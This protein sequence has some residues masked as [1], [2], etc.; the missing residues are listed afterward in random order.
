MSEKN[1]KI[2]DT[3]QLDLATRAAWL[4]YIGG[5]TQ[6]EV[7]KRLQVSPVKAHRLI[8]QAQQQGI[9]KI[10][11]EGAVASCASME[12]GDLRPGQHRRLRID[13]IRRLRRQV[14]LDK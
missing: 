4:S 11:I 1:T 5:Y 7:A 6:S 12:V 9:V 2:T 8:Q 14:G 13:E 10:Y 3:E